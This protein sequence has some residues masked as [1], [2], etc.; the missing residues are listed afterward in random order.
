MAKENM[1]AWLVRELGAPECS[2]A[3]IGAIAR[4]IKGIE[5]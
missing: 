3:G 5:F 2:I 1:W 4:L